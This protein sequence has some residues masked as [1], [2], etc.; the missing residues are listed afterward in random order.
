MQNRP[1]F[2]YFDSPDQEPVAEFIAHW[3]A[4]FPHFTVFGP[5]DA[6]K[7]LDKYFS[8]HLD[9]FDAIQIPAARADISRYLLLYELGGLYVDCH[10]GYRHADEIKVFEEHINEYEAVF[11][12]NAVFRDIRSKHTMLLIS[13]FMFFRPKNDLAYAACSVALRN[14]T[15]KIRR[16]LA[17]GFEPYDIW[18]ICGPGVLN[19]VSP[20]GLS[21][22]LFTMAENAP[23]R[24]LL[25]NSSLSESS[26][27][28]ETESEAEEMLRSL[29]REALENGILL[30]KEEDFPGKRNVYKTYHNEA[31]RHWS[32]RQ[33]SEPLFM[34]HRP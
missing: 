20:V 28:V 34:P 21:S 11:F 7:V 17:V 14:L 9:T 10:V 29:L 31:N 18:S 2:S 1:V 19:A 13:R 26:R 6:R 5:A 23:L 25:Q 30:L 22:T 3:R 15:E 4:A 33:K 24:R 32:E 16:E 8:G 27:W 12:D